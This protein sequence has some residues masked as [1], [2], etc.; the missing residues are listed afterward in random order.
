MAVCGNR[1]DTPRNT[2]LGTNFQHDA[3]L[4][5]ALADH[6]AAALLTG[7]AL[8]T[9]R[10]ATIKPRPITPM[11]PRPANIIMSSRLRPDGGGTGSGSCTG[12]S[13][14]AQYKNAVAVRASIE[15]TAPMIPNVRSNP[16]RCNRYQGADP[17][18]RSSKGVV[19]FVGV[20][21]DNG[22]EGIKRSC[23]T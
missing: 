3:G 19:R 23:W 21:A 18:A 12:K 2:I 17:D 9:M 10:E 20:K 4:S 7:V 6:S 8:R 22:R 13:D 15:P 14:I 11:S 5:R 1:R 16:R